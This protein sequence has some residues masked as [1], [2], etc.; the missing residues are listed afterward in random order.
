MQAQSLVASPHVI[1]LPAATMSAAVRGREPAEGTGRREERAGL[2]ASGCV[3]PVGPTV[4]V[5]NRR[6]TASGNAGDTWCFLACGPTDC[7]ACAGC[8]LLS[9]S[10]AHPIRDRS[11]VPL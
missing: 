10:L 5:D 7:V 11:G 6:A 9:K 8:A 1:G 2:V 4:N 3:D